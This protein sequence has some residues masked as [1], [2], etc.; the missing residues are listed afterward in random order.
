VSVLV[1]WILAVEVLAF[2]IK[3]ILWIPP[4]N[5]LNTYRLLIWFGKVPGRIKGNS[6]RSSA[7]MGLPAVREYF[8]FL[9]G[10]PIGDSTFVKLG[11]FAWL[12]AAVMTSFDLCS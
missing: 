12:G 7:A 9:E 10:R 3:Y 1:I 6:R 5:P 4:R 2:F 11:P 8:E